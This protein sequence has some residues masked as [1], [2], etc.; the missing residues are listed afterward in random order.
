MEARMAEWDEDLT[1]VG[2]TNLDRLAEIPD[3]RHRQAVERGLDLGLPAADSVQD[4]T[5]STSRAATGRRSPASTP[6]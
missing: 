6:S 1:F 5:I 4:R 2:T 3:D